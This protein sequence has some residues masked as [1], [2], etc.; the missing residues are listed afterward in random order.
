MLEAYQ[1][2]LHH[3]DE[4]ERHQG[5]TGVSSPMVSEDEPRAIWPFELEWT[6]LRQQL[7]EEETP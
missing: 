1:L 4:E 2:L 6:L 3:Q 7:G 5:K